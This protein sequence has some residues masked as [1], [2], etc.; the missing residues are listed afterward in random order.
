MDTF[1]GARSKVGQP[2]MK[3]GEKCEMFKTALTSESLKDL[4]CLGTTWYQLESCIG[5]GSCL[6][7]Y[8]CKT[9]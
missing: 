2:T 3:C 5:H 9:C 1:E 6:T 4:M 8:D 7:L